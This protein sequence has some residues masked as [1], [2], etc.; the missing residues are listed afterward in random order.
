MIGDNIMNHLATNITSLTKGKNLY[1]DF[2]PDSKTFSVVVYNTGGAAPYQEVSIDHPTVQVMV[3]GGQNE[4]ERVRA[5][6]Q[7][8]YDLLNRKTNV[9]MD[10]VDV[11]YCQAIQTP[12][13]MGRDEQGRWEN[14]CNYSFKIRV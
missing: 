9:T 2:A 10:T 8:I 3:R 14:V 1:C 4:H 11:M 5:M 12:Q 6:A 7:Q 13:F